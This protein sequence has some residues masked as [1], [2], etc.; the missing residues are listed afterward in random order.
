M[1]HRFH[2]C[3]AIYC[4]SPAVLPSP[5]S[6][7]TSRRSRLWWFQ[8]IHNCCYPCPIYWSPQFFADRGGR[9]TGGIFWGASWKQIC[10]I[11]CFGFEVPVVQIDWL[12]MR[13]LLAGKHHNSL[14]QSLLHTRFFLTPSPQ[15]LHLLCCFFFPFYYISI[16]LVPHLEYVQYE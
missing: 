3:L 13:R 15:I 7:G 2:F 14:F 1:A 16:L 11:L 6:G 8:V 12:L 10:L 9:L 4:G 5:S